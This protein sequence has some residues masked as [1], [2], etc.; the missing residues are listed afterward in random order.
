MR[1]A[2][3]LRRSRD[4]KKVYLRTVEMDFNMLQAYFGGKDIVNYII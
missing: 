4:P 3:V 2:H 1:V